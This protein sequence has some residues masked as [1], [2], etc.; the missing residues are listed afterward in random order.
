VRLLGRL[1]DLHRELALAASTATATD[2]DAATAAIGSDEG[3]LRRQLGSWRS[4][5]AS[6]SIGSSSP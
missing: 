3:T 6:R 4:E 1:R 2:D 5:I